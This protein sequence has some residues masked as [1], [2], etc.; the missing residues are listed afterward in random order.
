MGLRVSEVWFSLEAPLSILIII[1]CVVGLGCFDRLC[2]YDMA[3][4]FWRIELGL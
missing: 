4:I 2:I 1:G 3:A